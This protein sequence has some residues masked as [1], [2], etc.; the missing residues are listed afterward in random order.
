[1]AIGPNLLRA[2]LARNGHGRAPL[3][4]ACCPA[5]SLL[6]PVT[7]LASALDREQPQVWILDDDAAGAQSMAQMLRAEGFVARTWV[8]AGDFIAQPEPPLTACLVA[9]VSMP[10]MT[11][12]ELQIGRAHV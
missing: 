12:L 5:R 6:T 2:H 11:G 4:L 1:M 10:D 3:S 9:N 8:S 7:H